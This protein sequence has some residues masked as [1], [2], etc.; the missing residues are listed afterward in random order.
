MALT[1]LP[2]K[3][4]DTRPPGPFRRVAESCCQPQP[5]L[6]ALGRH[7]SRILA[8]FLLVS[9]AVFGFVDSVYVLTVP[10]Y[11]PP[12]YGYGL[13]VGAWLLNRC[14]R[15][16]A[17]ATVTLAMFP[18][19]IFSLVVTGRAAEPSTTLSY[20]VL[21]ILLASIL[22]GWRGVALVTLVSLGGLAL[23]PLLARDTVPSMLA[24]VGPFSVTALG[25]GLSLVFMPHRDRVERDRRAELQASIRELEMKN[26]EL[27]RFTY[28]VSHDLKGPLVTIRG[29]LGYVTRH[30]EEGRAEQLRED[31]ARIEAATERMQ[32]LLDEL[33][34]LSRIG[35]LDAGHVE[36]EI[37][38]DLPPVRAD[39]LRLV[40]L[41]QNLIDNATRFMGDQPQPGIHVAL[42]TRGARLL[43]ARQ[44]GRAG[45]GAA[46]RGGPRGTRLDR[47]RGPG[48]RHH[49]ALHSPGIARRRRIAGKDRAVRGRRRHGHHQARTSEA[50]QVI[51]APKATMRTRFP[52]SIRPSRTHSSQSSGMV[53]AV[54][55]P[56][57]WMLWGTFSSGS[58]RAF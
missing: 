57:L 36:V 14:G 16:G 21:G 19:V 6:D 40:E 39:R 31:V 38:G 53:A 4:A 43:R 20:L 26:T 12:W 25:A 46:H 1:T 41:L 27:E 48:L 37:A 54:V 11:A 28:T 42:R 45:T 33:L 5:A 17:A 24:L 56:Y 13:L 44:R 35:R 32:L 7:R 47:I 50:P 10:G 29:F 23:M 51:P 58:P 30:A 8:A 9:L 3:P 15:Y 34:R 52:G 49:R 22:L 55:F 18:L 2:S